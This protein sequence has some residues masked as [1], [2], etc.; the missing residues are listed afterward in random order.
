MFFFCS[1]CFREGGADL[2]DIFQN[3][4]V[5]CELG[6]AQSLH[7]ENCDSSELAH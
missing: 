1:S 5:S 6:R 7:T 3:S 2:T 4:H